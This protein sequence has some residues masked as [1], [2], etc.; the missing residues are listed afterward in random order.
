MHI[1][2]LCESKSEI[3]NVWLSSSPGL[4]GRPGDEAKWLWFLV[5]H[6]VDHTIHWQVRVFPT[7]PSYITY[8]R[9][10]S[11][12]GLCIYVHTYVEHT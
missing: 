1:L 9:G 8:L 2:G 6:Y 12:L 5:Q 4:H 11:G 3:N 10:F 7:H